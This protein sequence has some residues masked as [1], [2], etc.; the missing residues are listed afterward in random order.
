MAKIEYNKVCK[1]CG[2]TFI[3]LT[4][5]TKYCGHTCANRANKEEKRQER[6]RTDSEEI[7]ERNRQKMLS[8][9]NFSLTDAATLL[10][11]SRPT[12]YKLLDDRGVELLRISKRTIR[13]KKSDL[14]NLYQNQHEKITLIQP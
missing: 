14:L 5:T 7:K 13:V 3:A 1:Y 10:D 6:L 9:E 12:L 11:I 4:S 2:K 8:Q